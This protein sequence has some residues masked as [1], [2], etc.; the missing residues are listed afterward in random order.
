MADSIFSTPSRKPSAHDGN[1][2]KKCPRTRNIDIE[3]I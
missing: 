3:E 2:D 1:A